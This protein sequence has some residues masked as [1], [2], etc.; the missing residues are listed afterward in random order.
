MNGEEQ[1]IYAGGLRACGK[2]QCSSSG[3]D[4]SVSSPRLHGGGTVGG[5]KMLEAWRVQHWWKVSSRDGSG[6]PMIL[7]AVFTIMCRCFLSSAVLFLH[8][9]VMQ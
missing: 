6:T 9:E 5:V 3:T 4:A 7:S 8:Q 2:K 1:E